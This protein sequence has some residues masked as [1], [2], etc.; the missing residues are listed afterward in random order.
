MM[1]FTSIYGI[2]DGLFVSHFAGKAEFTAVNFI[3][4]FLMILG[5]LGF[6]FG[7]GGSALIAK[8]LGEGDKERA[9]RY[10]SL[11][12]YTSL[13]L[14]VIIS[15]VGIASIESVARMLGAEGALL[16]NS[17]IY[18]RI[19]LL[20]I[21]AFM[22]QIEFQTLFITAE[23]PTLGLVVTLLSGITNMILDVVFVGILRKG[24]IGAALATAISQ[25]I[26]GFAPIIY[27]AL[28]NS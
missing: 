12:V 5:T 2:V 27:F 28:K 8:T 20:A 22:L 26:G 3:M 17:V 11:V 6:M 19:V 14:G 4:P 15:A 24:L 18:G 25:C 9:N 10:F 21:P 13:I 23:K 1:I 16:E 7:A